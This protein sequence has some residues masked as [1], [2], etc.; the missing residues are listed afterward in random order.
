MKLKAAKIVIE[1]NYNLDH[2]RFML[3]SDI[4]EAEFKERVQEFVYDDLIDM[5][6]GSADLED[7]AEITYLTKTE[8]TV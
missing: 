3:G 1:M 5:M 8:E 2:M 4:T 7:W 6:R